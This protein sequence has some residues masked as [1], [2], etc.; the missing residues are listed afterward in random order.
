VYTGWHKSFNNRVMIFTQDA[1]AA[2]DV[3]G[4]LAVPRKSKAAHLRFFVF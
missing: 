3:G 2:A 4:Y 1:G